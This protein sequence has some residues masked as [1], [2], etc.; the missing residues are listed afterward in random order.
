MMAS[1]LFP[2]VAKLNQGRYG[3][4]VAA[5]P[6]IR[7][8]VLTHRRTHRHKSGFFVSTAWLH[9]YGR[10][11]WGSFGSA[12]SYVRYANLHGSAHH[13]WRHGSGERNRNIGS[14][15]MTQHQ[16]LSLNPSK[17]RAA[18]HRAIAMAAL[19]ADSSLSVRLARY[20]AAMAR[21]RALE[22]VGGAV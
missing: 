13:D 5:N 15:I 8:G 17:A 11:V 14:P 6:A 7:I 2:A 10:A 4:H 20:N 19:R 3:A 16:I 1:H 18:Y 12:G 22:V 9:L 21:A